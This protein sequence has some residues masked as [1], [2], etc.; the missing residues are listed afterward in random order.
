MS[1]IDKTKRVLTEGPYKGGPLK[2]KAKKIASDPV[3]QMAIH[4]A[5][6]KEYKGNAHKELDFDQYYELYEEV[7]VQVSN[8]L[9]GSFLIRVVNQVMGKR[10]SS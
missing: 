10:K 3:I 8:K 5:I 4:D 1:N 7:A 6:E 9:A 2:G